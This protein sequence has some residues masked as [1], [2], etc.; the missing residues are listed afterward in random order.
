M[1]NCLLIGVM[2][3]LG[4]VYCGCMVEMC[5]MNVKLR[6]RVICMV[7][8]LTEVE[9]EVVEVVLFVVDGL[10]KIVVVMLVLGFDVLGAVV[11]IVE[12][13]GILCV[14]LV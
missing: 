11:R 7:V 13:G 4:F 1:L 9:S 2:L 8:D 5:L 12:S 14:V 3:W 10:I 6:D